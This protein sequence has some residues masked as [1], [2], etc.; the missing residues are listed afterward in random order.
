MA[1]LHEIPKNV[2]ELSHEGAKVAQG[3]NIL[4]IDKIGSCLYDAAKI[5]YEKVMSL[6]SFQLSGDVRWAEQPIDKDSL[7]WL[8]CDENQA[9][10]V[11]RKKV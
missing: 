7:I 3:T 4:A 2:S 10:S 8:E 6:P 5:E 9:V 1:V 11:R